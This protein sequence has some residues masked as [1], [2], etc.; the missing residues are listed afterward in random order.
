[1]AYE[2][3]EQLNWQVPDVIIYPTGG[4]TGIVGMWKA[5]TEMEKLGLIHSK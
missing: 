5:F 1:M 4:G 3:V 2:V